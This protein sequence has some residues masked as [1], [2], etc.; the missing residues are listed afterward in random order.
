MFKNKMESYIRIVGRSFK[1]FTYSYMG[2]G[3]V[4]NWST[5]FTLFLCMHSLN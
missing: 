1:N 2:V 5:I 3:G 4:K